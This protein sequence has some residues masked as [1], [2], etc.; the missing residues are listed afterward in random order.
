MRQRHKEEKER[1]K[2]IVQKRADCGAWGKEHAEGESS[3]F[4]EYPPRKSNSSATPVTEQHPPGPAPFSHLNLKKFKK[5]LK[6]ISVFSLILS[7]SEEYFCLA[8]FCFCF[9]FFLRKNVHG[10]L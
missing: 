3:R 1:E 10:R 6:I 2:Q 9:C 5:N 8:L 4:T 7:S